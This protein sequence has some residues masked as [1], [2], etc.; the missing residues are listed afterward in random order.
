MENI[1]LNK[2]IY[3]KE[4]NIGFFEYSEEQFKNMINKLSQS[5]FSKYFDL[6]NNFLKYKEYTK[7]VFE[8]KKE[9]N[10]EI[11]INEDDDIEKVFEEDKPLLININNCKTDIKMNE[12]YE[13]FIKDKLD[14]YIIFNKEKIDK[15]LLKI[16]YTYSKD[17][18][19]IINK[20]NEYEDNE[21]ESSRIFSYFDITT[22]N[23][24]SYDEDSDSL[25]FNNFLMNL[26][27]KFDMYKIF[28]KYSTEKS[29][30]SFKDYLYNYNKYSENIDEVS[31]IELFNKFEKL[32][33]NNDYADVT[34]I[35]IQI[36][37]TYKNIFNSNFTFNVKTLNCGFCGNKINECTFD[38]QLKMFICYRCNYN[39]IKYNE[40]YK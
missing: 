26:K 17:N 15:N 12:D 38:D 31:L 33:F 4:I 19:I 3:Q 37:T 24:E 28:Q 21:K 40:N 18:Y 39:K 22:D 14:Y 1:D 23:L 2:I 7:V 30:I 34:I 27:K 9:L 20:E 35:L 29:I 13:K 5:S 8:E 6:N 32:S 11:N 16:I 10:N 36:M 25:I